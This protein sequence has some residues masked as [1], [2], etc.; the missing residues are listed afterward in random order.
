MRY[1]ENNNCL[2]LQ[3]DSKQGIADLNGNITININYDNIYISGK[4]VNAQIDDK[5]DIYDYSNKQKINMENVIGLNETSNEEYSIAIMNNGNFKIL[6]NSDNK[7]SE[8]EYDYLEYLY[9][10]LFIT[11][12][13]N[14]FGVIDFNENTVLEC[15]YDNIRRISNTKFLLADNKNKKEVLLKDKILYTSEDMEVFVKDNYIILQASADRKYFDYQ[16]NE[17]KLSTLLDKQLYANTQNNKWGFENKE[18]KQII[19][20]NY[21]FVTEFNEYGFAGIKQN[22]KW[23]VINQEGEV[24]VEPAYSIDSNNPKFIGKYYEKNLGYGESYYI[25]DISEN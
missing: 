25:S 19:E 20:P 18:E 16:G 11:V 13:D 14:K 5:I 23:G 24:I 22:G 4:Y 7:L 8:K 12:K 21:D 9:D 17:V 10:N 3:K 2:I 15:K 6:N 1:D